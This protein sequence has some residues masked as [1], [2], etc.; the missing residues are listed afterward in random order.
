MS[1][2]ETD[3]VQGTR[4]A[5]GRGAGAGPMKAPPDPELLAGASLM[6]S[7]AGRREKAVKNPA[8]LRIT[9]WKK[10]QVKS[11]VPSCFR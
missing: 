9:R 7:D 8:R 5:G 3:L 10:S 2:M 11:G 6:V 4:A 1:V